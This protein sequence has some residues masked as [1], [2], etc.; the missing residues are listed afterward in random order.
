MAEHDGSITIDTELDNTGFEKGSDQLLK[1]I[2]GVKNS[3]DSFG[4]AATN[5]LDSIIKILQAMAAN[6][7]VTA[8][9]AQATGGTITSALGEATQAAE[10]TATST[11]KVGEA[12]RQT[13]AEA[14]KSAQE[15]AQAYSQQGQSIKRTSTTTTVLENN[16]NRLGNTMLR[17]S[18]SVERGFKN[19][20]AV[21][22]F[23]EKLREAE[24]TLKTLQAQVDQFGKTKLNTAEYT[25]LEKRM[26]S[27]MDTADRLIAHQ[28]V[29]LNSGMQERAAEYKAVVTQL[30]EASKA[31]TQ[32]RANFKNNADSHD[33][34]E[35]T[36]YAQAVI[37]AKH[38][39]DKL[40]ESKKELNKMGYN[41]DY[42]AW[43]SL[44][45]KIEMANRE[46][47]DYRAQMQELVN[48]GKAFTLGSDTEEYQRVTAKLNEISQA[49]THNKGLINAEALEQ[50]R[51]NMLSA[52]EALDVAKTAEERQAALEKLK[53]AQ[54]ALA[55]IANKS[56][57][58]S[59]SGVNAEKARQA[60]EAAQQARAL[61]R[62][63]AAA[64]VIVG[65]LGGTIT[66]LWN[67]LKNLGATMR[68]IGAK[69]LHAAL[70]GVA[71]GFTAA[72]NGAKKFISNLKPAHSPIDSLI[73]K[74][75]GLKTMMLTRLKR[76]LISDIFTQAKENLQSLAKY[77]AEFDGA[78]SSIKNSYT[79]MSANVSS[80]FGNL[81]IAVEPILTRIINLINQAVVAINTLFALFRGKSTMTV[82]K[83]QTGSYAAS[84]DKTGSSAS[85]AAKGVKKL[86][87]ELYGWDELTKQSEKNSSG[88]SGGAGGDLFTDVPVEAPDW[89]KNLKDLINKGDW[90]GL[91][92][93][94]A[95]MLAD[96]LDRIPWGKIYKKAYAIGHRIAEFFNGMFADEHLARTLG[97]TI[98]GMLNTALSFALGFLDTFDFSQFGRWWGLLWNSF[99][100]S[101]RWDQMCKVIS[102]AGNG[103][104]DALNSFFETIQSACS[105]LGGHLAEIFNAIFVDID[106]GKLA[107]A[108]SNAII[109]LNHVLRGFN[110]KIEW[111][112]AALNVS[113]G[114]NALL[115]AQ[116]M[117]KD[118]KLTSIWAENGKQIG[119]LIGGFVSSI[120]TFINSVNWRQFGRDIGA[121]FSN[122]LTGINPDDFAGIISGIINGIV[123]TVSGFIN[124][125]D[126]ETIATNIATGVNRM[127]KSIDFEDA[128]KTLHDLFL[129]L[130]NSLST[131]VD[132]VDWEELGRSIGKFLEELDWPG[133]FTKAF[134]LA[135]R[136]AG[137]VLKGLLSTTGGWEF[138]LFTF[139]LKLLN[140]TWAL[141]LPAGKQGLTD[142]L[143]TLFTGA[144]SA[145]ATAAAS[146]GSSLALSLRTAIGGAFTSLKTGLATWL[147]TLT[148]DLPTGLAM[149]AQAIG[150]AALG[151]GDAI[152][153]AYDTKTLADTNAEY[154]SLNE[155][156]KNAT[157]RYCDS[158]REIYAKG[159][160][161]ALN[162]VT[163][164]NMSLE[165]AIS[166]AES[167]YE[168]MP[169]NMW[170]GFKA[171]WDSYFGEGGSGILGLLSDAFTQAVDGIKSLLGIASPSKVFYE[172]G[173]FM[174]EGLA[175]GITAAW[176]AITAFFTT[177]FTALTTLVS[178]LWTGIQTVTTSVWTA[179]TSFISSTWTS[180]HATVTNK[181]TA[182][183][184]AL[185]AKWTEISADVT[186]KWSAI[187]STMTAKWNE[188]KNTI[189]SS[190]NTARTTLAQGWNSIKSTMVSSWTGIVS[191]LRGFLNNMLSAIKGQVGQWASAGR[192]L[193]D[194][195][196][197]GLKSAWDTAV[198]WVSS[199]ADS[200]TSTVKSAFGV[201]S[202][203]VIWAGIGENLGLGLM[204]GLEGSKNGVIQTASNLANAVT[205]EMS[206]SSASIDVN[207]DST[208]SALDRTLAV[209]SSIA[210]KFA[211]ISDALNA[212]GGLS[213]PAIAA[214]TE[215][216]YRARLATNAGSVET[217]TLGGSEAIALL[218]QIVDAIRQSGGSASRSGS[219]GQTISVNIDG[220]EI[221]NAVVSE[222]NKTIKRT[223][224]SPLGV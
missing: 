194:G 117:D 3:I 130:L 100:T 198:N 138:I 95:E 78:M 29:L 111:K 90:F 76:T 146:F 82:A 166:A 80:L 132:E 202:P 129:N 153:L 123:N 60:E 158:L 50:A 102:E 77:S 206:D 39:V 101:F 133:I 23:D 119:K 46:I 22:K 126:W 216:P 65:A 170:D 64:N 136:V 201:H 175:N 1:A 8:S 107:G 68:G 214:G 152:L 99:V 96:A 13:Q 190:I 145:S 53:E 212:I 112:E 143:V 31:L 191:S 24:S 199:A 118:G 186:A 27:A 141:L 38:A 105:S 164:S 156:H 114:V 144:S 97:K 127:V 203:S 59:N 180:I 20:D 222:N 10:Q 71:S 12:I 140:G 213:I 70:N 88:G 187:S 93:Q 189:S 16:V 151:V 69:A 178:G 219:N 167:D 135:I 44:D 182:I 134:T 92:N 221:F 4:D 218:Q 155:E 115:S 177:A 104:L 32:A 120:N 84:L 110:K 73:R 128:G 195:L 148:I 34:V 19:G 157:E 193:V 179:I 217:E 224:I 200:L 208:A 28:T 57:E 7:G 9:A 154:E 55:Y 48:T 85:K 124:A 72:A 51:L 188:I 86:K 42:S 160:Q 220:R 176:D 66:E 47:T 89:M 131:I 211:A 79:E 45:R 162:A 87:N 62:A 108:I 63:S 74:L 5:G 125:V 94:I 91:G 168:E 165:E 142:F 174:I 109:D 67:K 192:N 183:K 52:Q 184:G 172:I 26:K 75:T 61:S 122:A 18:S 21:L 116:Q 205:D 113:N 185:T 121:W 103:I 41:R 56:A 37:N 81:L 25:S 181:I 33:P 147:T 40:Y 43:E 161:E 30:Q 14:E 210:D 171:G 54:Q 6:M 11:A 49:L 159:G 35:Y 150:T 163:G 98:A 83:T 17:L 2:E 223:G 204:Q 173:Q 196:L 215:V 139:G 58:D 106:F 36:A 137:D 197:Q 209:L 207:A 169:K 15:V 149:A